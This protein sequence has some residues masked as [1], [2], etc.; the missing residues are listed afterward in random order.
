MAQLDHTRDPSPSATLERLSFQGQALGAS[1]PETSMTLR[2]SPANGAI[3]S[4]EIDRI[5]SHND[6][7]D[8]ENG[9]LS[10]SCWR[11]TGH[12]G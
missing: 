9:G 4:D 7:L 8:S 10:F 12:V 2:T 11:M 3:D 6:I 5:N 1:S